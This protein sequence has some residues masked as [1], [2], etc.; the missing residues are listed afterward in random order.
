[1]ELFT[2]ESLL[3]EEG[4]RALQE[5]MS[6][7]PREA[8]YLLNYQRLVKEYSPELSR[9]AL[10]IA[11]LRREA[12]IKFPSADRLYFTRPALEQASSHAVSA[13]RALR[14]R[15]FSLL[16]DLGC[17]VGSDTF[18]LAALAPTLG[19]DRDPLRLAMARENLRSSG[20]DDRVQ[21]V[22][23]DLM[24]ELP[25]S[26]RKE[27]G[28][29]CDPSRRGEAGRVFSVSDYSPPLELVNRWRPTFQAM[30]VKIS[31]GVHLSELADFDAEV[32]F[33]SL[34]GELKEAVL[35]FGPLKSAAKRASVL[36]GGHT[37]VEG[38]LEDS[39]P[40]GAPR[41]YLY[42][43]DPAVLRAGLVRTLGALL[44]AHQLDPDIAYLTGDDLIETPFARAWAVEAWF[45]FGIKRLRAYLRERGVGRLTVKK[46][47]SP[48]Q[49]EELIQML[50][51]RGEAE[52][53]VVLTHLRGRPIV[54]VCFGD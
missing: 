27:I 3:T 51:L 10:E 49:P 33:I 11:I 38:P 19:L 14:F 54:V 20:V 40:A 28:L 39:A 43:P 24:G 46:R 32:E 12:R 42:E 15:D 18:A 21:L 25:F 31:P 2:F 47:G 48:L 35:W 9:A 36:P 53:V 7:A 1:V 41:A 44:N 13:Y 50:K 45:P 16:V 4:Q 8:D 5:A 6:L 30:G 34:E 22:R 37:L 26:A 23:A 17:S 29:F 52:R